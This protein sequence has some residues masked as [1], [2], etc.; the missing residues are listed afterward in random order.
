MVL[1]KIGWFSNHNCKCHCDHAPCAH[2][3]FVF[4]TDP[5][6]FDFQDYNLYHYCYI[7]VDWVLCYSDLIPY[8]F[9]VKIIFAHI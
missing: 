1:Q 7:P 9:T 8:F 3:A 5:V 6:H 4:E 2:V